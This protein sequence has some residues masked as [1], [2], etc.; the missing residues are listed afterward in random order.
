MYEICAIKDCNDFKKSDAIKRQ[1]MISAVIRSS[2]LNN[3][4]S[5]SIIFLLRFWIN[6]AKI[7]D[8]RKLIKKQL[9][10]NQK[11]FH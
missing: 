6:S 11:N 7:I 1:A 2:V 9:F 4:V 10:S 8:E 5:R 3:L